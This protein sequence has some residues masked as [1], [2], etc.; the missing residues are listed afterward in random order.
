MDRAN[1]QAA[2]AGAAIVSQQWRET[3][4]GDTP[5]SPAEAACDE[6]DDE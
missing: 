4:G 2:P 5:T 3:I 1:L 6:M